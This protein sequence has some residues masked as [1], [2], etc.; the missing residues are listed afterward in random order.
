ME[1]I[2]K[3]NSIPA[4]ELDRQ[5]IT[6]A[7]LPVSLEGI[8]EVKLSFD[9]DSLKKIVIVFEIPPYESTAD[10]L[11]ANYRREKERVKKLFGTPAGDVAELKSPTPEERYQWLARGRGYC[12]TIWKIPEATITLWLYAEDDGLVFQEIY[13]SQ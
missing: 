7:R 10:T 4:A 2:F 13:E 9:G 3:K 11:V 12:R 6:A 8:R 1:E 5:K